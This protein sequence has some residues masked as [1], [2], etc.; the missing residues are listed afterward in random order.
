MDPLPPPPADIRHGL[1]R[2]AHFQMAYATSNIDAAL[3][4]FARR[5]GISDWFRLDGP[6]PAGGQIE[7][8]LAWAGG[9]MIELMQ[10]TGPGA[11]IYMDRLPDGEGFRL[12]QHHLG[13]L[14]DDEDQWEALMVQADV[15][16]HAI[17]H[18]SHNSGLMKSCFV[19][20]PMLGHYLEYICPEDGGRALFARVPV[21]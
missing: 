18:I 20:A 21:N 7:C 1:M 8:A 2:A 14:L 11:A 13:Y 19:D 3:D 4:L 15:G 17:P 5:Y 6:L 9:L 12:H 10:A 16:N